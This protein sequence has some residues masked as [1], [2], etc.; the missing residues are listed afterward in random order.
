MLQNRF[1]YYS[2][3]RTHLILLY[4]IALSGLWLEIE[5]N[6]FKPLFSFLT[7]PNRKIEEYFLEEYFLVRKPLNASKINKPCIHSFSGNAILV[8]TAEITLKRFVTSI[9]KLLLYQKA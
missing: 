3:H 5:V 8:R 1:F 7:D 4:V 9:G 2:T 6:S